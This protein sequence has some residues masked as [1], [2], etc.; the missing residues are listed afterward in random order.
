[1][2]SENSLYL[3]VLLSA[4]RRVL[5]H[6]WIENGILNKKPDTILGLWLDG[7]WVALG[8]QFLIWEVDAV[9][10]GNEFVDG[11]SSGHLVDLVEPL[12]LLPEK[13]RE[14]IR[15]SLADHFEKTENLIIIQS[16]YFRVLKRLRS[17]LFCLREV[18]T[19][20]RPEGTE[21]VRECAQNLID[22]AIRVREVME[23]I[24]KGVVIP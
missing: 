13:T 22:A 5:K 6:T 14:K 20:S 4:H 17:A 12:T 8:A 9:N 21:Q 7:S 16:E 23:K 15:C 19:L 10:F 11:F 18:W 24:P 2:F 1:M 3:P